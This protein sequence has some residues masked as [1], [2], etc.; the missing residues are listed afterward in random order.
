MDGH[1]RVVEVAEQPPETERQRQGG[2][3]PAATSQEQ[4]GNDPGGGDIKGRWL[5]RA[6]A[7]S[8]VRSPLGRCREP[9]EC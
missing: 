6:W 7:A 3:Q 4:A 1:E 9:R 2:D 8:E 5:L